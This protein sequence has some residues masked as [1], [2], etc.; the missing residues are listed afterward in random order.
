MKLT[1]T[2]PL[3]NCATQSTCNVSALA[4]HRASPHLPRALLPPARKDVKV[5][6]RQVARPH[7]HSLP[8]QGMRLWKVTRRRRQEIPRR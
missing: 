3:V 1:S 6:K 7:P 4:K 2:Q 8:L 5:P